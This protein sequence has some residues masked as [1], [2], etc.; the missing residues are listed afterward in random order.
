MDLLNA[1]P[2]TLKVVKMRATSMSRE[3]HVSLIGEKG[4]IVYPKQPIKMIFP[5]STDRIKTGIPGLDRRVHGGFLKGTTTVLAGASGAGKTTFGFQFVAQGVLDG[6]SSIFCS[7]EE[8][9]SKIRSMALSL[10]FG[11]SE[12]E[13]ERAPFVVLDTRK[14]KSRRIYFSIVFTDRGHKTITHSVG[15]LVNLRAFV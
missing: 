13:K 7:L 8:S 12:L 15:W 1:V 9:P 4:M 11:V 3:P 14:S 10:G 6:E 5:A 2:T